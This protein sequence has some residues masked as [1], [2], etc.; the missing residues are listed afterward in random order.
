MTEEGAIKI[1]DFGLARV[2]NDGY[3]LDNSDVIR[4]THIYG[5]RASFEENF[6]SSNRPISH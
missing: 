3:A 2:D 5:S 1:L 4:N 6:G